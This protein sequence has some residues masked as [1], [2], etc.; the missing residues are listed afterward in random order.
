V[1][2]SLIICVEV[3]AEVR[4]NCSESLLSVRSTLISTDH[5]HRPHLDTVE[6]VVIEVVAI[7]IPA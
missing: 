7:A 3:R 1:V 2:D 4:S 5:F 6:I